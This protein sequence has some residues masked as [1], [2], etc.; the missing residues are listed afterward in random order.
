MGRDIL[1]DFEEFRVTFNV[2]RIIVYNY[3]LDDA[4]DATGDLRGV[5]GRLHQHRLAHI[6]IAYCLSTTLGGV[7]TV[8]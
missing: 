4:I 5:L 7:G 1:A 3:L 6:R 2:K 8:K